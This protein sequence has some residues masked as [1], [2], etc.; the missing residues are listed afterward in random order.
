MLISA[1]RATLEEVRA[2][3][4]IIHVRDIS[5]ADSEAQSR[6][7]ETILAELGVADRADRVIEVWNKLDRLDADARAELAQ[8]EDMQPASPLAVSALTGE[9]IDRLM[10]AIEERL[11]RGRSLIELTLDPSDGRGLHWLYEHAEVMSRSDADDGLHLT[12][13]VAPDQVDRVKRRFAETGA[14]RP[15]E[16]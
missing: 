5:H 2:A 15:D 4:V 12:V 14:G 8:E 16:G 9:G 3:D 1:F 11:A 7:V 6:D 10:A 13:R